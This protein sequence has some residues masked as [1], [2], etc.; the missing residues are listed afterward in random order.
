MDVTFYFDSLDFACWLA[1]KCG[2]LREYPIEETD[3]YC[4]VPECTSACVEHDGERVYLS[5]S[6]FPY[7]LG[8]GWN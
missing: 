8:L 5:S 1:A 7:E 4:E 2:Q 3:I 6:V